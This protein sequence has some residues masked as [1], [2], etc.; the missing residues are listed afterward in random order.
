M[1]QAVYGLELGTSMAAL[2]DLCD[3]VVA[4]PCLVNDEVIAT[5]VRIDMQ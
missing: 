2:T 3:A 5:L 4:L 1:V